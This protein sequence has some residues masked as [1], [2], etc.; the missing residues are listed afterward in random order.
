[1]ARVVAPAVAIHDQSIDGGV[2]HPLAPVERPTGACHRRCDIAVLLQFLSSGGQLRRQLG[3]Q[4]RAEHERGIT[5]D[6]VPFPD[7]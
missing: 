3:R 5:A 7:R 6:A 2:E 4:K 1:M